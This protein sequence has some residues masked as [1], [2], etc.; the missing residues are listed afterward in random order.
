MTWPV[1]CSKPWNPPTSRCGSADA[2]EAGRWRCPL[3]RTLNGPVDGVVGVS[4]AEVGV[5]AGVGHRSGEL[6]GWSQDD[7]LLEE[8]AGGKRRRADGDHPVAAAKGEREA[9][10]QYGTGEGT[11][12]RA[13]RPEQGLEAVVDHV[14]GGLDHDGDRDLLHGRVI[15]VDDR[16]GHERRFA[17]VD[18]GER[19]LDVGEQLM[20]AVVDVAGLVAEGGS[21]PGPDAER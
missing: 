18:V 21:R 2:A 19:E 10:V 5:G 6:A 14:F 17:Q 4:A 12:E 9:L 8:P 7:S 20:L 1:S 13:D 16:P 15:G 3:S 11:A